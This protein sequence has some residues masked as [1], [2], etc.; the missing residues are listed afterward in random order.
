VSEYEPELTEAEKEYLLGTVVRM[1]EQVEEHFASHKEPMFIPKEMFD[2]L[3][4]LLP[5]VYYIN[6][7]VE[8]PEGTD[9]PPMYSIEG[10][11]P[12]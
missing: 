3:S 7:N 10:Y 11:I 4:P 2:T 9:L 8:F 6:D 5:G 1:T 12:A